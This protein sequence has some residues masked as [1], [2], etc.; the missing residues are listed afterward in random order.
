MVYG[1]GIR[2]PSDSQF[3]QADDALASD[4]EGTSR[5]GT[6]LSH[7]QSHPSVYKLLE[8]WNMYCKARD[9]P[10]HFTGKTPGIY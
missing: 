5:D 8:F 9:G 2:A 6:S 7:V 1:H 3:M 10:D 4:A